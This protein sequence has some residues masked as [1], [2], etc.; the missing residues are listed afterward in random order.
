MSNIETMSPGIRVIEQARALEYSGAL[1]SDVRAGFAKTQKELPPKYFYDERGSLLFEAICE[2]P[3]YY[4]TRTERA[5]LQEYAPELARRFAPATLIEFG[6]GS[7]SK[8]RELLTAMQQAGSLRAYVPIDISREILLRSAEELSREYPGMRV[9]A[10]IAD[11][12]QR[13]VVPEHEGPA[14][15]IFLGGTIGNFR[16]HEAV[17]FLANVASMMQPGD[18]F[19]LGVDLVKE[20]SRLNAAYNDA[21]GITADFNLN[22]LSVLNR[23]LSAGFE[24]ANFEHYAFYNPVEAQIEM[25]LASLRRQEIAIESLDITAVFERGETILTEISRKFNRASVLAMMAEAGLDLVEMR[26]DPEDLF[27]L[28]LATVRS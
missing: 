17:A 16:H 26:A 15:I 2:V 18:L 7:S 25:H 8:T 3:E 21:A 20:P 28:C 11:F 19:L 23:E 22:V 14:L 10:V 4:Q 6:S 9:D 27:A 24:L 12:N 5:I 1:A 13:V